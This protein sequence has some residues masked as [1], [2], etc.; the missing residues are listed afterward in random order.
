VTNVFIIII[1]VKYVITRSEKKN[2]IR[3]DGTEYLSFDLTIRPFFS[4]FF[5]SVL[6][7]YFFFA[8]LFTN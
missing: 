7:F 5:V 3:I 8:L 4:N 2:Q 1:K 6:F